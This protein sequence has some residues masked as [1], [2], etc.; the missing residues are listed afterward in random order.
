MSYPSFD[1]LHWGNFRIDSS[2]LI[3]SIDHASVVKHLVLSGL[4]QG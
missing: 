4:M 3:F 1:N 2:G